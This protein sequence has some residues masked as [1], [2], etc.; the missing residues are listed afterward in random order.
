MWSVLFYLRNPRALPINL[1]CVVDTAAILGTI[2]YTLYPC[3]APLFILT[4]DG[5]SY[6]RQGLQVFYLPAGIWITS[7][8]DVS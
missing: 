8:D 5:Q 6:A 2:A 1:V 3:F 7:T 4:F